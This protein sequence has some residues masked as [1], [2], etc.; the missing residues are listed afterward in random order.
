MPP[1]IPPL[2]SAEACSWRKVLYTPKGLFKHA[3]SLRQ[4]FAHCEIFSTAASRRS[5]GRVAVPL[6]GNTL[7]CPLPVIALV[8]H[9][10]TN[11]LISRRPFTYWNRLL[12]TFTLSEDRDYQELA[13]LSRSYACVGGMYLRVTNPFAGC[14]TKCRTPLTCMPYPHR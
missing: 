12:E 5:M 9:Y 11:K 1:L 3:V 13:P 7:S 10:P 2:H 6:L 8:G 4:A 14:P